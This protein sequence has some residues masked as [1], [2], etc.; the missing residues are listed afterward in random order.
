MKGLM[1]IEVRDGGSTHRCTVFQ[2][3]AVPEE[4]T[5]WIRALGYSDWQQVSL[6]ELF[7]DR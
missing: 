3:I 6:R 4:L 5:L 7:A 2:V 1:D